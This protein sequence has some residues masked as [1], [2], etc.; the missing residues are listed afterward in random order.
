MSWMWAG[1]QLPA[2]E[3]HY[4]GIEGLSIDAKGDLHVQTARG[5]LI[6]AAPAIYQVVDGQHVAVSGRFRLINSDTYAFTVTGSFNKNAKL[7]IDPVADWS[8][9][10]GGAGDDFGECV[11]LDSGNPDYAFVGG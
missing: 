2:D 6:D 5:N 1:G 7:V 3:I 4:S 10:V 11:A 8:T 9:D